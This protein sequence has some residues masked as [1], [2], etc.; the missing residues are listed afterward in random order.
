MNATP[1]SSNVLNHDEIARLAFRLW[2]KEGRPTG[3][4]Q[5]YS[6][7]A[8]GQLRAGSP[9]DIDQSH[10]ALAQRQ[11]SAPQGEIP[12]ATQSVLALSGA[13]TLWK[14]ALIL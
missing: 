10:H 12:K 14:L 7:R 2:Q 5:K 6:L 11:P 1:H 3:R 9:T 4:D 13:S 8:Q